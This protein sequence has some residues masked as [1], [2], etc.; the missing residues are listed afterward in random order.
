MFEYVI[1][2]FSK[3]LGLKLLA[4]TIALMLWFYTVN[5]LHRGSDEEQQFLNRILPQAGMMAKKL[6]IRPIFV[7]KP[8]GGYAFDPKK[9]VVSPEYCIVVG[10]KDLLEKIRYAY[11]VP[12]DIRGANKSFTKSIALN[13]IAPG[14]FTEDTMVQITV[15]VEKGNP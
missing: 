2:F 6:E 9:V 8:R 10:S 3:N 11:T 13:P 7:G 15:P 4:L 14:V 12:V 1:K 5:E